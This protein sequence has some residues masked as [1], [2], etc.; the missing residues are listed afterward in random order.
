MDYS[1]HSTNEQRLRIAAFGYE[2][3]VRP[4]PYTIREAMAARDIAHDAFRSNDPAKSTLRFAVFLKAMKMAYLKP[5]HVVKWLG[6]TWGG[7]D[8]IRGYALAKLG[9]IDP[10]NGRRSN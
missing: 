9:M 7:D 1:N 2:Q 8:A 6:Q 5:H 3:V 10:A 4:D